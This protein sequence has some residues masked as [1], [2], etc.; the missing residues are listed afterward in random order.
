[1]ISINENIRT[2]NIVVPKFFEKDFAEGLEAKLRRLDYNR[3]IDVVNY[4]S[5]ETNYLYSSGKEVDCI[6]KKI[7]SAEEED[8]ADDIGFSVISLLVE[9]YEFS[10]FEIV[11]ALGYKI[12]NI[13][14]D[15]DDMFVYV[16]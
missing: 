7:V 5:E 6:L 9:D 12:L 16:K 8:G 2:V 1:M 14:T 15:S 11:E 3:I 4:N 10:V 13:Y